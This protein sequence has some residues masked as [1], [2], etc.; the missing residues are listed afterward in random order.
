MLYIVYIMF[1]K[2]LI[3]IL[4]FLI[5]RNKWKPLVKVP[6]TVSIGEVLTIKTLIG[7]PME[8]GLRQDSEGKTVPKNI[9]NNFTVEHNLAKA[10][11]VNY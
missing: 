3:N 9:I 4:H 11:N 10:K 6:K 2:S 1:N 8:S 7:H 5:T